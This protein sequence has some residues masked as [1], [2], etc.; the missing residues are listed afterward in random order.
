MSDQSRGEK[1]ESAIQVLILLGMGGMAGAVSFVHVHDWTV[2]NGQLSWV[3]WT[4]AMVTELTQIMGGL[5]IRR[6]K[7]GGLPVRAIGGVLVAAVAVSLTAQVSQAQ[8]SVSGWVV[9]AL[10]ALGFLTAVKIVMARAAVTSTRSVTVTAGPDLDRPV[11]VGVTAVRSDSTSTSDLTSTRSREVGPGHGPDPDLTR[12][13]RTPVLDLDRD[14]RSDLDP[15]TPVQGTGHAV[16]ARPAPGS[17]LD[18]AAAVTAQSADLDLDLDRSDLDRDPDRDRDRPVTSTSTPD[19]TAEFDPDLTAR[20]QQ[21]LTELTLTGVKVNR[22][23]FAMHLRRSG[24]PIQTNTAG[25]LL[26]ALLKATA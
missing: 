3:G 16:T 1:L 11:T 17:D 18:R 24:Q 4:N 14:R 20:G 9:A 22:G 25:H 8:P 7:R 10:P 13:A 2:V 15:V 12:S 21:V 5:E 6:R 23:T 19:L 26:R